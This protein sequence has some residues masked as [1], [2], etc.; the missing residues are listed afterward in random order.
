VY[1]ALVT[2]D[3]FVAHAIQRGASEGLGALSS[4]ERVAFLISEA[5]AY[6]DM[7][8]IDSFIDRY[9]PNLREA[10]S[11]FEAAGAEA[12]A[13]SLR[14]IDGEMPTPSEQLLNAANEMITT[15]AGYDYESI[16]KAV[17]RLRAQLD[18]AGS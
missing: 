17:V 11:A 5:E 3:E 2:N 13:R 10:A 4:A 7:E 18:R 12:I 15:R 16:A 9:R 14:Q 8:G 6:C 1:S